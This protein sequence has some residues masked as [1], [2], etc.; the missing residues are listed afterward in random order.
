MKEPTF[1]IPASVHPAL[2]LAHQ[3]I[4]DIPGAVIAGGAA[5]DLIL[6]TAINDVDVFIPSYNTFH[7][8]A[9]R[10]L[11]IVKAEREHGLNIKI[12]ETQYNEYSYLRIKADPLDIVITEVFSDPETLVGNFDFVLCQAW[13][14]IDGGG[15]SVKCTDAFTQHLNRKILAYYP[16]RIEYSSDRLNRMK[17]K[18]PDFLPLALEAPVRRDDFDD[19]I[20]F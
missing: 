4:K 13:L 20:P 11:E 10:M 19:A 18:L 5:R 12:C 2:E 14:E 17:H 15:F 1:H 9:N 7:S 6:E 8:I 16:S 3:F